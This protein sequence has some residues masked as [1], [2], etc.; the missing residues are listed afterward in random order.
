MSFR[1]KFILILLSATLTLY[2]VV[3]GWISTRAQQPANDPNAQLRIFESVLQHIQNDYVDE[4]NMEKVRAGALRGLA[5]GLDPYSTYLTPEQ[6]KEYNAANKN[7]LAGIGAELSQVASYLYVIAPMKGSPADQAGLKAGDIIEYIDQKATRDI[8]L[9][10]AKQLLNGPAGSEVKLRVLR[11]NTTPLTVTVKRGSGRAAAAEA[12][13]E[14]G[15]VGVLR[16][17]SFAD[18]ESNEVRARLQDL[19]K[20]GAQKIVLDLRDTAGGSLTEAVTVANLFIKDGVLAQTVGREG[21]ALKTFGADPKLAI[22]NGPVVA[23]IDTGTAG[24]AE[25]VASALVE[26]NRGQLVGEKSFGAGTEQQL[27]TLRGGDGLLLTTVKWASAGGKTFLGEDR[28]NTGVAP[29]V[30]VKSADVLDA[31]DPEELTGND[32]DPVAK[33]EQGNEKREAAPAPTAPKPATEDIQLKKA[34]EL[35]KDKPIQRAA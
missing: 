25:V 21:K 2:T 28:A 5:Y 9:Y 27:F 34:L 4:P 19:M 7:S 32:D 3:G 12:R 13:M 35:L 22:F 11:A 16:I 15:R 23:V 17:N 33:P 10:D 8:S 18:G 24:A 20:Q 30:E 6:V 14:A 1:N 31:V 29:T 26:R